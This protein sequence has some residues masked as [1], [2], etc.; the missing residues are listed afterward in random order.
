MSNATPFRPLIH[1][2]RGCRGLRPENTLPA[3]LHALELGVD[4]LEMDV[5]ISADQQ[6][7]VSHEPWLSSA[8]CFDS[9]GQPIPV[10]EEQQH[11]L[12]QLPYAIIH[13]CDC[14]SRLHPLFP[15]QQL[16]PAPKPLLREVL[17]A[18]EAA[19]Q[20][21]RRLPVGYSIEVKSSPTG[22]GLFHPAP[23]PFLALVAAELTAAG[24]ASRSTIL[25]F[26][27]RILQAARADW[28]SF[29]TCLLAEADQTWPARF[30]ELG[31]EPTAF[32]PDFSTV[33]AVAVQ[34]LRAQYP[35]LAL[36]PWTVNDA[37]DMLRLASLGVDGITT[38]YPDRALALLR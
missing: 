19:T 37:S 36:A 4:V 16:S 29:A 22:D 38:D 32:G 8:L 31:F 7:V 35:R 17:T 14:G 15:S 21:L 34:Q 10:E 13:R 9:A 5:V 28:P 30:A 23:R 33:S 24:V 26:D 6:V 11:N 27:T 1:G 3:F 18:I 25:S 20:R 2:H 12:Y